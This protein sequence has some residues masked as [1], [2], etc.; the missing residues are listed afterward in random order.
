MTKNENMQI[1]LE[2][3]RFAFSLPF[4]ISSIKKVKEN[5]TNVEDLE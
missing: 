5:V 2:K 4:I 3:C 1:S